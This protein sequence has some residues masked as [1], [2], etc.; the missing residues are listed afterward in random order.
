VD[1]FQL[2]ASNFRIADDQVMVD[3]CMQ[4][5]DTQ[6]WMIG[7]SYL[8]MNNEKLRLGGGESLDYQAATQDGRPGRRCDT[9][10]FDLPAGTTTGPATLTIETVTAY[11]REG[12]YCTYLLNTVQP[13]LD[14]RQAG[15]KL[16]CEEKPGTSDA[17]VIRKPEAM[18]Q[19]EAEKIAFSTEFYTVIGPWTFPVS[20]IAAATPYPTVSLDDA[21]AEPYAL[22]QTLY[23]QAEANLVKPGWTYVQ[24]NWLHD[25]DTENFGSLT[26]QIPLPKLY[27]RG[28][29]YQLDENGRVIQSISL[30]QDQAGGLLET[31]IF[32]DGQVLSST[33]R[34][35]V[36]EQKPYRLNIP[37][38]Y[39]GNLEAN[40]KL[41]NGRVEMV[42]FEGQP[43]IQFILDEVI[44][45][46][47]L[48]WYNQRIGSDQVVAIFD[49]ESGDLRQVKTVV[50]LA[51]GS[52]RNLELLTLAVI[53][54]VEPP[55][56]LIQGLSPAP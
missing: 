43:A 22:L 52:Q 41:G 37:A 13:T 17:R 38:G 19:E 45:A 11:P 54:G 6:D 16:A 14:A 23:Q 5:P 42:E 9:L 30:L 49:R 20:A 8:V 10:S 47:A 53:P 34:G 7:D 12:Q 21:N 27:Q 24:E 18:S 15:I 55:D 46:D 36:Y 1:P 32:K 26:E 48:Q 35:Q 51:D 2:E 56:W 39:I 28:N 29:W 3:V 50:T 25:I 31:V 44:P 4:M 40:L 33:E